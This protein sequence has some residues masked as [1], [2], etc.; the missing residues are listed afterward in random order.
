M[1]KGFEAACEIV[2]VNVFPRQ[3]LQQRIQG[4]AFQIVQCEN[5]S[6]WEW[7]EKEKITGSK[8]K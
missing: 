1:V 7:Y 5:P 6:G 2:I 3:S 8:M 4:A